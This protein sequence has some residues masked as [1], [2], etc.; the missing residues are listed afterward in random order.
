MATKNLKLLDIIIYGL[1]LI[2]ALNW[3][4]VGVFGFDLVA[5]IFGQMT[6]LSRLVYAIV[7]LAAVYDLVFIKAIWRRWG[8][9]LN[10]PAHA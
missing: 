7:G 2:G 9:H 1:L 3:G 6:V 10:E 4:L 5:F 8:V